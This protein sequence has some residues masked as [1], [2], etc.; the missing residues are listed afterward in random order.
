MSELL[1]GRSPRPLFVCVLSLFLA[2][3]G[4]GGGGGDSAPAPKPNAAPTASAGADTTVFKRQSVELDGSGSNDAD[5]QSLT[6]AWSQQSGTPVTLS[7]T[8]AV[9]PTFTAPATSGALVF[10]LTVSDGVATS[11]ADTVS[12]T[13]QN[14]VPTSAAGSD[15]SVTLGSAVTLNGSASFDPDQDAL[16]YTWRQ[17]NGPTVVVTTLPNGNAS[18][19]APSSPAVLEFALTVTDGELVSNEDTVTI[20]CTGRAR[21]AR[22]VS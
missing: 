16:S 22:S 10:A 7:S 9:R 17:T 18:F 2:A 13:I 15:Q 1:R 20:S 6:H 5:G 12:I 11:P 19:T 14:R 4:G 21:G 8:S 3:C